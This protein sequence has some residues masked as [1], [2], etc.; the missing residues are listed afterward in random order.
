M[1]TIDFIT[2]L[3]CRVDDALVG[4]KKHS[5]ARLYPSEIVTLGLL[6]ALKGGSQRAFYRWVV[7]DWLP[8]FPNLPERTR[9][10]ELL[11]TH[12]DWT[13]FFLA[14]PTVLGVADAY[15]IELLHPRREGRSAH[16]IGKKGTSNLR[17]IVGGKL[18]FVLNQ[19]GLVVDWDAVTANLADKVFHPLIAQFVHPTDTGESV[20]MI[21]LTDPGFHAKEGDPPNMK[22]CPKGTWNVRM[23]V[24]TV[25]SMLTNICHFKHA[26]HRVWLF[27]RARLAYV[28][29][30]FNL[31]AQWRGLKPDENGFIR[32]SI[33]EFS[34]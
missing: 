2:Q 16:Q 32:L 12:Q 31:L 3:F 24:E 10:F 4:I 25:L 6:F 33:A 19:W 8:L 23:V 14:E 22:V 1:T 11:M 27:F 34:L 17:W 29:A 28:M 20:D 30:L 9:L 26:R 21:V 5:Q 18:G 7:R 15:G 13:R